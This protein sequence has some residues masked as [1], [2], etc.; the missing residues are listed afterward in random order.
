MQFKKHRGAGSMKSIGLMFLP[1]FLMFFVGAIYNSAVNSGMGNFLYPGCGTSSTGPCTFTGMDQILNANSQFTQLLSSNFLGFISSWFPSA[2]NTLYN[3]QPQIPFTNT[4]YTSEQPN[5]TVN[6]G[7]VYCWPLATG[8]SEIPNPLSPYL[9]NCYLQGSGYSGYDGWWG[10]ACSPLPSYSSDCA[11]MESVTDPFN[12]HMSDPTQWQANATAFVPTLG[13]SSTYPQCTQ[14]SGSASCY[15]ILKITPTS[16]NYNST[17]LYQFRATLVGWTFTNAPGAT[18]ILTFLGFI[19]G[20]LILLV[21]SLG[22]GFSA[23]FLAS[24]TSATPNPQGTKLAQVIG[25][26]L[27]IWLPFYSEFGTWF[28]SLGTFGTVLGTVFTTIFCV[29]I[30]WRANSLD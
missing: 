2:Q 15:L 19:A 10:T 3:S 9:Y 13:S 8:Q 21:L 25:F 27:L 18:N 5:G 6:Q 29:A 4:T 24:G 17:Y 30:Y 12:G 20:A 23:T 28:G 1:I 11:N 16:S 22:I 26:A 14:G 7:W